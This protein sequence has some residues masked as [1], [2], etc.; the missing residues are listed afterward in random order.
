MKISDYRIALQ[1]DDISCIIKVSG[2]PSFLSSVF[3]FLEHGWI[4]LYQMCSRIDIYQNTYIFE[5][6]CRRK[7]FIWLSLIKGYSNNCQFRLM[8]K[9]TYSIGIPWLFFH[10]I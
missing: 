5:K 4:F 2:E 8:D 6:V 10:H 7:M 1:V 3:V 9:L